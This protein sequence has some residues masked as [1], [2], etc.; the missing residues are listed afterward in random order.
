M[1]GRWSLA[2]AAL[3]ALGGCASETVLRVPETAPRE[4]RVNWVRGTAAEVAV[5]CR[6]ISR[7]LHALGGQEAVACTDALPARGS[8]VIYSRA[9]VT[10]D[11][12]GDELAHCYLGAWHY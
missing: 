9:D 8:C 1:N 3:M 10:L 2:F 6:P 7:R 4:M 12:L 5:Y 11:T